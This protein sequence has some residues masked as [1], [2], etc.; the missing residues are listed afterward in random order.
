[1]GNDS[2][3]EGRS[4]IAAVLVLA[5]A[6]AAEA[7]GATRELAA[8]STATPG[9]P[10]AAAPAVAGQ[11]R[12]SGGEPQRQQLLAAIEEV[13]A[14]MVFLARPIARKRLRDSNLPSEELQLVVTG[15]KI[16]ILRPGRPTVSAP[17]NGSMV[18]WK[19]PDGDEFKVR[20]T[21]RGDREVVQEFV[22]DGNRSTNVFTLA[23]D[24][25]RL[26]VHTTIT[27]DRLPRA[28]SFRMTYQRKSG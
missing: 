16:T 3:V 19:S 6:C 5:P 18:V 14:D 25:A 28:L 24:G 1:M 27:A 2:R 21:L 10:D 23:D 20:H 11:Y 4:L 12:Y 8:E 22:G 15:D 7:S 26:T 13:V 9:Q 17:R